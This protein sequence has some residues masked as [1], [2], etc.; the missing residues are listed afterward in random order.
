M[1]ESSFIEFV[2]QKDTTST[3]K[4]YD[5]ETCDWR[6]FFYSTV[7]TVRKVVRLGY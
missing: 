7:V 5:G 2:Q 6:Y 4:H 3:V 1:E